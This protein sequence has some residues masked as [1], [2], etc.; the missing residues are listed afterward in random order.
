MNTAHSK[1]WESSQQ[2]KA[3]GGKQIPSTLKGQNHASLGHNIQ[4]IPDKLLKI[5]CLDWFSKV[6]ATKESF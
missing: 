1:N 3:C 4:D 5:T 2:S 6:R